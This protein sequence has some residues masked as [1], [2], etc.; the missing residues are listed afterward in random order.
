[1]AAETFSGWTSYTPVWGNTGTANIQGA[2]TV[3]GRYHVVGKIVTFEIDFTFGA[4]SVSGNAAWTFTLPVTGAAV[5]TPGQ[6][7]GNAILRDASVGEYRGVVQQRSPTTCV[8]YL[9]GAISSGV[10]FGDVPFT[11]AATDG[12][13][14]SGV[15]QA[16]PLKAN[17]T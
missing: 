5:T 7:L 1:M 2:A 12:L 13:T 9:M 3:A 16:F 6:I 11:W 4:G 17:G 10:G 14:I 8:V 15:Y